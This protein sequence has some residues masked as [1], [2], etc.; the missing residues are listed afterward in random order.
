VKLAARQR[1]RVVYLSHNVEATLRMRIAQAYAGPVPLKWVALS[2][3]HKAARL[4]EDIVRSA[5]LLTAETEDDASEFHSLFGPR[6]IHVYTPG[7]DGHVVESRL[8]FGDT[9]RAVA[10]IGSR[11]AAMKRLVLD[12]V[13]RSVAPRLEERGIGIVVAGEA[14]HDYLAS[15][16]AEYPRVEFH[17]Y[18][19]DLAPLLASVRLGL[20]TDHIGGGFKHRI[21]TLV[22]NRVPIVATREA[23]AG[24]PLRPGIHYVEVAGNDEAPQTISNCID[25]FEGLDAFQRA[26]FDA[27]NE[28]FDWNTTTDAF[29]AALCAM[30][31][32]R[33]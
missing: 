33:R 16:A 6:R 13:L 27:C 2:D 21:L 18:V 5:T 31:G 3:A 10:V 32:E 19:A 12:D 15:R 8:P 20:I 9:R 26:A 11:I 7:Y 29:V 14:S 28:A 30:P 25:D 4:E 23:M 1:T 17:G 22:F 24:L